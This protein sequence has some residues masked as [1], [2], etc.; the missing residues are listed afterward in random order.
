MNLP[1]PRKEKERTGYEMAGWV[2]KAI[3]NGTLANTTAARSI[4]I[5]AL[6]RADRTSVGANSGGGFPPKN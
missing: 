2:V 5:T 1:N 6:G 3:E 4:K